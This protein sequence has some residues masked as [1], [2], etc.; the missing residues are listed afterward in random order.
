VTGKVGSEGNSDGLLGPSR[1]PGKTE[2]S[3]DLDS[4]HFH[5]WIKWVNSGKADT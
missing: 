5:R 2:L 1:I 4:S 3:N